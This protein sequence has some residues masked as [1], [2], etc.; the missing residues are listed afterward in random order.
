MVCALH[1]GGVALALMQWQEEEFAEDAA[2][3]IV[4]ELAPLP[5]AT[6]VESPDVAHG[7]L[8]QEALLTPEAS[9]QTVDE[10]QDDTPIVE[11]SPAS[12]SEVVLPRPVEH[13]EQPNE[14]PQ[15]AVPE[16]QEAEQTETVPLTTAPPRVEAQPAPSSAPPS[17]ATSP[18]L[19]RVQVSWQKALIDHLNRHKRYPEAA[20]SRGA[21]GVV[22]VAFRIDRGGRVVSAGVAK[23][24][25]LPMLDEEALA[26][27]E[28]ASPLPAPPEHTAGPALDLTLPIQFRIR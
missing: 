24:S 8:M 25:G 2:G 9:K 6:P 1:V 27:L 13:P 11:P 12:E 21:Q 19:A 17:P 23:S 26:L 28:R 15:E 20:R 5:V 7:P 3:A 4:V 14:E 18:S 16:R 22:I 10:V